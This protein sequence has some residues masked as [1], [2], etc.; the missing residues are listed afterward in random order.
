M[1]RV[2]VDFDLEASLAGDHSGTLLR[3]LRDTLEER[4][5]TLRR[6][7]DQGLP[8]ELFSVSQDLQLA[9]VTASRLVEDMW[10]RRH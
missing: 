2:P 3:Q 6:Q 10:A 4:R 8:P 9:C 7:A 5:A 1:D